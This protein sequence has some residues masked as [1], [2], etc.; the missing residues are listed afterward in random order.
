MSAGELAD[1]Q[2]NVFDLANSQNFRVGLSSEFTLASGGQEDFAA[3]LG[4]NAVAVPGPVVGAG[5][6]GFFA[7]AF[8]LVAFARRR[9]Q[10]RLAP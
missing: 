7:A 4:A 8:V 3:V 5:L 1:L 2:T 10:R 6:P 9:R